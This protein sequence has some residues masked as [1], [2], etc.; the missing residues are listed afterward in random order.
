MYLR[1]AF[2]TVAGAYV[3][4]LFAHGNHGYQLRVM[5]IAA[6][7]GAVMGFCI[8]GMFADRVKRKHG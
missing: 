3:A 4:F 8:G 1:L 6:F 5:F 7:L 2:W